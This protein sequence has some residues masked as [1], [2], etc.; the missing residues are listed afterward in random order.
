MR[1]R[2]T[3]TL[4]HINPA[5]TIH[6]RPYQFEFDNIRLTDNK[7][8][9]AH[10][11]GTLAHKNMKNFKYDFDIDMER[12][13]IYDEKEF[14]S[15]KFYATV[16]ATGNMSLH[17]SDGHPLRITADITPTR[18][19]VFA[20]DAATPDA[21]SSTNFVEFRDVTPK[22]VDT[23][24]SPYYDSEGTTEL[25]QTEPAYEYT[26]DIFMD[27]SIHVNPDCEIKLR[28][29]NVEDGYMSTY[30]NGTLLAHYHN[31]S[32]FSLN[33]IYQIDGGKYRLYL[34]DIIYRDLD[35]QKG[36]NVIFNGNP[37]D[38]NIHLIC[39]H[40][41]NSV[42]LRDLT[43]A[44]TFN[45][46]SKVKVICI[47]DI[48][49]KLG[50]MNFGF[51]LQLPNVNDETRQIVKSLISSDEEMNMQMIYL[52]GLGRFYTNE[53]A[54]ASGESGTTNQAVNTLL[55]STI[56]GQINQMLS[57][58]I[59]RDSKW[60]FGT[61]LSTGEKGWN[62]LDVE[63]MLS[64]RLLNDRLLING[65]FG[66]RDN[67]L[68]NQ[69]N[70]IGD[71]DIKWRLSENGNTYIKAYN[72]TNDRYFTKATLNTQGIGITYQ[73]DFDSWR[74]LFRKKMKETGVILTNK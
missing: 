47:L 49:G 14:N 54:R 73:R 21:I 48:T 29:D 50:N 7:N 34:Q 8:N 64:G 17:G 31:K 62:D 10:V 1:L 25:A 53:Y 4:Y 55:S 63:G 24:I 13:T 71:F 22:Q 18:G 35:L 66:Y 40:T 2:A 38:A 57:N 58:V 69:A 9:V 36:S 45:Q 26:G 74:A 67:A 37:F 33:G 16:F 32:P 41:I 28:M 59:G 3:N 65:N 23:S 20:Y 46:D 56:S 51:D 30:G 43:M 52:L 70:F 19:S 12:L 39:H 27:I 11:N 68:T 44:N 6:L 60:N 72:K 15:D 61:G 5:D 42:P